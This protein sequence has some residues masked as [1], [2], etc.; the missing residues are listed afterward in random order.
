MHVKNVTIHGFKSYSD[1]T[2]VGPFDPGHNVVVGRNGSGKSNFFS[3]IE[4]VLTTQFSSLSQAQRC[5]L[6]HEGSGAKTVNAYVDITF[7]N[8]ERRLPLDCDE[9][10][11]KRNIG[12]KKDQF[13]IN[14]KLAANRTE[15]T[16]LLEAAGLSMSNPYYIVKQVI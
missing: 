13:Y 11:V 12:A 8:S 10:S 3:A 5:S 2:I 7:D 15:V 16:S 4:F 6:L 9:V 1:K 14:G